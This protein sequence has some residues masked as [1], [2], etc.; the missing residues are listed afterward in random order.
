MS[1]DTSQGK[2]CRGAAREVL[3]MGTASKESGRSGK[4]REG[5]QAEQGEQREQ[6]EQGEEGEEG[7][8]IKKEKR[9]RERRM[10]RG[11]RDITCIIGSIALA[12]STFNYYRG[13]G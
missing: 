7:E 3:L 13:S 4:N 2:D 9:D 11:K 12:Q 6:G 10:Q 1:L 8:I 5:E